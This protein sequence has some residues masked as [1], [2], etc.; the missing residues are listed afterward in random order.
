MAASAQ[1]VQ[2]AAWQ[3]MTAAGAGAVVAPRVPEVLAVAVLG[4]HQPEMP[5]P[6]ILGEEEAVVVPP[7]ART[8]GVAQVAQES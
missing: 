2:L 6:Q 3:R 7:P 4:L 1:R 8:G 5:E